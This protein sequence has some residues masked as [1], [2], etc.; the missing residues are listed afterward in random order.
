MDLHALC[1]LHNTERVTARRQHAPRCFQ[2]AAADP[3]EPRGL[4]NTTRSAAPVPGTELWDTEWSAPTLARAATLGL[5]GLVDALGAPARRLLNPDNPPLPA[6][7]DASAIMFTALLGAAAAGWRHH[8]IALFATYFEAPA[9]THAFRQ[10]TQTGRRARPPRSVD[11]ILRRQFAKAHAI[12]ARTDRTLTALDT[13]HHNDLTDL[14]VGVLTAA[15]HLAITHSRTRHTLRR[16][17]EAMLGRALLASTPVFYA[18]CR[19]IAHDAG[20]A[21]PQTAATKIRQL[22]ALGFLTITQPAEGRR[23]NQYRLSVPDLHQHH[24][25]TQGIPAPQPTPWNEVFAGQRTTEI[26]ELMMLRCGH[27][28]HDVWTAEDVGDLAA[29]T[30]FH[31][32]HQT[33]RNITAIAAGTGRSSG[34]VEQ[35]LT[36]LRALNLIDRD[37]NPQLTHQRYVAAAHTTHTA[38]TWHRRRIRSLTEHHLW[39]WWCA[40]NEFLAASQHAKRRVVDDT[41]LRDRGRYPRRFDAAGNPTTPDH[42]RART[43]IAAELQPASWDAQ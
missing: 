7:A 26:G 32:A 41:V 11:S 40:E 25:W 1:R 43:I 13:T 28:R 20:I 9:F 34:A 12:A 14:A 19:D 27:F 35:D 29:L 22:I 10:R 23:A 3:P 6:A 15:D 17:L 5:G 37:G 2:P 24:Q 36:T 42:Q 33:G 21:S 38:G 16:V 39:D 31:W 4:R 8:D 30:A 18:G